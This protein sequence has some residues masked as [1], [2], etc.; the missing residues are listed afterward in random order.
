M[1][2][3]LS[4]ILSTLVLVPALLF[5]GGSAAIPQ[6]FTAWIGGMMGSTF[7]VELHEGALMY[8]V[9]HGRK[10]GDPV[11]VTPTAEQ[12]REFQKSLDEINVWRWGSSY[13][14][15]KIMDGTQWAL[16]ISYAD[17]AIK[18]AG[19]NSYPDEKGKPNG[20]PQTTPAFGRYLEAVEKLLGGK[21]FR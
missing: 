8:S 11:K 17:H 7:R 5:A 13:M 1:H 18:T 2:A 6:K 19:S 16:D 9:T 12:W 20:Q 10:S 3:R 14:N 15:H 21:A 4:S